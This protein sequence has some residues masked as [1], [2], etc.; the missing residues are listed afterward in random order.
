MSLVKKH[1]MTERSLAACRANG[2]RS[3]GPKTPEGKARSA[4]S[5]LRHGFY[6]RTGADAL[7]ALSEHPTEFR[8]V[9]ATLDKTAREKIWNFANYWL[10]AE[11]AG[12]E[13]KDVKK[14]R[15]K[16]ECY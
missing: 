4:A 13:K 15:A 12:L 6:S 16:P 11:N 8:S 10:R 14:R 1:A 3:R 2:R 9:L 5:R 7:R